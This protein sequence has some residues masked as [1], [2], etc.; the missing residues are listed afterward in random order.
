MIL[1]V[2]FLH[3]LGAER[4]ADEG[5]RDVPSKNLSRK[6][7]EKS[8]EGNTMRKLKRNSPQAMQSDLYLA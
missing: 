1:V 3:A 2:W 4:K 8:K 5:S 7:Q 6:T